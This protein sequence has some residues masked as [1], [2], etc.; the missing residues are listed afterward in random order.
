VVGKELIFPNLNPEKLAK[1]VGKRRIIVDDTN[2]SDSKE[3]DESPPALAI[4]NENLLKKSVDDANKSDNKLQQSSISEAVNCET[5]PGTAAIQ[6]I[7]TPPNKKTP[8]KGAAVKA[9]APKD[10]LATRKKQGDP[11]TPSEKKPLI[12][13][14]AKRK[15]E[16]MSQSGES[17]AS[18]VS[19]EPLKKRLRTVSTLHHVR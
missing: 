19:E 9:P 5:P 6:T 3:C 8:L 10:K 11:G 13:R 14:G 1:P 4:A 18:I 7:T 16:E 12:T 17:F 15:A 2:S